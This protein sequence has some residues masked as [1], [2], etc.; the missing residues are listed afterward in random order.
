[1]TSKN[2]DDEIRIP[3]PHE[4]MSVPC[5]EYNLIP[6]RRRDEKPWSDIDEG[7]CRCWMVAR[8]IRSSRDMTP[9]ETRVR[10]RIMY[11]LDMIEQV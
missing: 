5:F 3:V 4:W 6:S 11:E 7:P 9:M 1:M 10:T 2:G 8:K